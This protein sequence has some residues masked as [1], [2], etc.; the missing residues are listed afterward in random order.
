M[1]VCNLYISHAYYTS[2]ILLYVHSMNM[3]MVMC[4]MQGVNTCDGAVKF[5]I[6]VVRPSKTGGVSKV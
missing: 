3:Q 1:M 5:A 2:M 6:T 4:Y